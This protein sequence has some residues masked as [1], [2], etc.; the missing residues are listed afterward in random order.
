[1]YDLAIVGGGSA[2]ASAATFAGRAGLQTVVVD[3]DKGMTRRA[4]LNNHLGFPDGITGPELV[5]QGQKQA[6]KAGATWIKADVTTL[7]NRDGGFAL[8]TSDGQSVEAREILLAT[9]ANLDLA[10]SAGVETRAGT[11]P[12]IAE[13]IAVNAEGRTNQAGIWAAGV[14]AGASVHTIITAGEGAR[15][16]INI[17]SGQ[18]GERWVDHDRM[19]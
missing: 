1:M 16:A 19:A 5:D 2:G 14:S 3:G 10:R 8:T 6:E 18:K 11:E 17:I 4:M 13:V 9:G 7:E 15:V 12:R